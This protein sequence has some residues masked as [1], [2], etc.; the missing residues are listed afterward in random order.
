MNGERVFVIVKKHCHEIQILSSLQHPNV[1]PLLGSLANSDR[2]CLILPELR[3]KPRNSPGGRIEVALRY[4]HDV[5]QGLKYL[6]S[7]GIFHGDVKPLNVLFS[8]QHRRWML[9]DFDR[10]IHLDNGEK[11]CGSTGTRGFMAPEVENDKSYDFK[12]DMWSLGMTLEVQFGPCRTTGSYLWHVFSSIM[13]WC[14][15]TDPSK[16]PSAT[17]AMKELVASQECRQV[18][19]GNMRKKEGMRK[20]RFV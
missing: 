17:A 20:R 13:A 2:Y 12:A 10:A 16:R 4:L 15:T 1:A 9:I 5:L 7:Q 19:E 3:L 8:D 6:H 14:M 18:L 11:L